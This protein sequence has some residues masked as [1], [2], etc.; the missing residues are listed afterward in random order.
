MVTKEEKTLALPKM[1]QILAQQK[2]LELVWEFG[3]ASVINLLATLEAGY[4]IHSPH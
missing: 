1:Y 4:Q 3:E 2:K